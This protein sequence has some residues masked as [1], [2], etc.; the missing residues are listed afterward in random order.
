MEKGILIIFIT[1]GKTSEKGSG[2]GM[3]NWEGEKV[4]L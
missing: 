4:L 3:R 1:D 2:N